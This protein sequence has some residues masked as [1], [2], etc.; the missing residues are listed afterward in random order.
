MP[1]I[2]I[3]YRRQDS[4]AVAGR[5]RDR[6]VSH[7]GAESVFMDIDSIPFGTDFREHIK[8]VLG[9]TDIVLAII[10]AHW[11]GARRGRPARIQEP[12]DPVRIE[13]ERALEHAVP[14]VPVLVN[15]AQIP[16]P[17]DLPD[18]LQDLCYLNAAQ[19]DSGRDFHP[20]V[21]R[22]IRSMDQML[23]DKRPVA[24]A[25]AAVASAPPTEA[26]PPAA[27]PPD[28][29]PTPVAPAAS[30]PPAA[31]TAAA[32]AMP[33]PPAIPEPPAPKPNPRLPVWAMLAAAAVA[34]AV[35]VL[36]GVYF[37]SR[38]TKGH[39]TSVAK[40]A[41]PA[42]PSEQAAVP[43][44]FD[45]SCKQDPK[46]TFYDSFT[47]PDGGW[48]QT[49]DT[50]H[51]KN[52]R[53][54]V[55][56]AIDAAVPW[57]YFP[58]LF[59]ESVTVCSEVI[60]PQQIRAAAGDA[61][62]GVIFW[63]V[64]S[65]TYYVAEIYP[66]G[67]FS[68]WR[69]LAGKWIA[70]VPR[71]PSPAL[72]QGS[73][74]TNQLKV[75]AGRRQARLLINGREAAQFWGQPPGR[76]GAVGL[77][78]Q[79]EKE[80]G[81]AWQ[82]ASI[83]VVERKEPAPAGLGAHAAFLTACDANAAPAFVDKFADPDPGWGDATAARSFKDGEMVLQPAQD[84]GVSWIYLPLVFKRGI[85]CADIKSPS[86]VKDR[87]GVSK[88]GVVFWATDAKNFYVA[89]LY[90]D[91]SYAIYRSIDGRWANVLPRTKVASL[92]A[93]E[94]AVNRV[95]VAFDGDSASLTINGSPVARLQHG[96]PPAGGGSVG[97]YA[98]SEV[99]MQNQWRI[100]RIAAMKDTHPAA[101]A[102]VAA[103]VR[104]AAAC[105][106]ARPPAFAD[107]FAAPDPGW[108]KSGGSFHFADGQMVLHPK[109]DT[110]VSWIYTP[111]VFAGATVCAEFKR[112]TDLKSAADV[113][114]GGVIFWARDYQNYYL[115]AIF[116]D[117]TY[118]VRRKIAGK[119]YDIV[120]RT[121][122]GAIR[123]GPEAVNDLTVVT[124]GS[125]ATLAINNTPVVGFW[126]QMPNGGG[127]VG[128]YGQ[129]ETKL[130]DD[131][132]FLS[133][134]V[135]DHE[136]AEPTYL[137]AAG[138]AAK[139]C[140]PGGSPAFFDNF[141]APDPGWGRSNPNYFFRNGRM[142]LKP[143]PGKSDTW[144]YPALIFTAAA[145]CG[146]VMFPD[147]TGQAMNT[148]A[149]GIVFWAAD[150]KNYHDV[151]L[152]PDGTY[153]VWR[154]IDGE[155]ATVIPR[156]SAAAIHKGPGAV[157]HLKVIFD[158]S[159]VSVVVNDATVVSFH[160]QPRGTGGSFGLYAASA[161]GIENEWQFSNLVVVDLSASP[162]S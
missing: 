140:K 128:L 67:T 41:A 28:P 155:W 59:K 96:Q 38:P 12:N 87:A 141:A 79:S 65:S 115:A 107:D 33:Q 150:L 78:G 124:T 64:D 104:I 62:G 1:K 71:R 146:D 48:G 17:S 31:A 121:R 98:E 138:D 142:V 133:I 10:G 132:R 114:C 56:P 91:G 126:G 2:V 120:P 11:T 157:N 153:S 86:T 44:I 50:K 95:K 81:N 147:Q 105:K 75:T 111:M 127:A 88:G 46:A 63:A 145:I 123:I 30:S 77:F 74:A 109:A 116:T 117:G 103:P 55:Q 139:A 5:I 159:E 137:A 136:K 72:R 57:I 47:P 80:A 27:G 19:V 85:V 108:G 53:M 34:V 90:L 129:S 54:V 70:V 125:R 13:V 52:G 148:A 37:Y 43:A 106:S 89:Q 29:V 152:Y 156:T 118:A 25:P 66:N 8:K 154:M 143:K 51:F 3:S 22:L 101:A 60:T 112:P 119:L 6:L 100:L 32:P 18:S 49:S 39:H 21:D 97:L 69:R 24:A 93:G 35:I 68:V 16:K 61:A 36:G 135:A 92:H 42:A 20:H 144:L 7:Y 99:D 113:A 83:S 15:A 76:G 122:S 134:A 110:N 151:Q 14:L 40:I 23:G 9:Q 84:A 149:G 58:A 162:A 73:G 94:D 26:S 4:E 161:A 160:G 158:R 82:F 102:P 45:A 130:D 131:W